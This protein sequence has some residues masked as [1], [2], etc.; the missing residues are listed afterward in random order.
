M[1][2]M[3]TNYISILWSR[4]SRLERRKAYDNA[5]L[6]FEALKLLCQVKGGYELTPCLEWFGF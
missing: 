5:K 1:E 6:W 4:I 3:Y 2:R